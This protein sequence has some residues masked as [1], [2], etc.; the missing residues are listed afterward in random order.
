MR[1]RL[2]DELGAVPRGE[3]LVYLMGPYDDY[4]EDER[5]AFDRLVRV[6]DELR[7][8]PGVNAFLAV[9]A[10]VPLEEMD[11]ATQ[12][13]AFARA[14]DAVVFVAPHRGQNLGVGI[15]VGAILERVYEEGPAE[16]EERVLFVR[17]ET[18]RSALIES[19]SERW[20]V[21]VYSYADA[22]ELVGRIRGFVSN[23]VSRELTG[24]LG[25]RRE[26]DAHPEGERF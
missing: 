24:E 9:D 15:E 21:T 17:E 3:F 12:S 5:S 8:D 6:R 16:I 4:G 13:I 22:N 1:D 25:N 7:V 2:L 18:V 20:N 11:A 14:S 26:I 10:D 23:L 19:L